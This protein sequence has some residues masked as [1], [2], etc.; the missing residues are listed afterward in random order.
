[1][2][3]GFTTG[4]CSA[5]AAKAATYMLLSGKL[6]E[7][8][9]I[10]T[11]KGIDFNAEILNIKCSENE[12]TCGVLKDGGDDPDVTSGSIVYATVSY[13]DELDKIDQSDYKSAESDLKSNL[14]DYKSNNLDNGDSQ[15][16]IDGGQGVGR[17]TMPGLDQPVGNAAINSVPRI[18]IEKEVRQ[19]M[20]VL[21]Y[22][23]GLKIIISIPGGEKIAE[24]TFNPRL[25]I[26][27]GLSV[28]GTSGIVE[29]MSSQALLDTIKVELN[30]KKALGY[31]TIVIAPGNYGMD[32]MKE[33]YSYNLDQAVKCSNFIGQTL[34]MIGDLGFEEVLL[35]GHVG[36]LIKLSG[37]IM[38]THSHEADCR[39]E[40][41]AAAGVR[42]GLPFE[43]LNEILKCVSTDGAYDIVLKTGL[44]KE[45]MAQVMDKV[46]YY[47]KKKAEDRF[48]IECMIYSNI[49]GLMGKTGGADDL[50]N[51]VVNGE[52]ELKNS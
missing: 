12:V 4:S 51:K 11:P 25:G 33:T 40:L 52:R 22:K 34:D 13:L 32:F 21:D 23:G 38:N 14:A 15:I 19:V 35:C 1:M 46:D 24:K 27:G 10:T 37:G 39:M 50:I 44:E 45:F 17:V 9:C 42:A 16:I 41:M 2:R 7:S 29:P 48:N 43:S 18:M 30:Q 26:K 49:Y 8:I 31:K 20:E 47:L 5:A 3:Y 6:K 28:L 36:K